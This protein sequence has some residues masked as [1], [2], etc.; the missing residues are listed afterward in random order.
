MYNLI[1]CTVYIR[2]NDIL[3]DVT[4]IATELD[5]VRIKKKGKKRVGKYVITVMISVSLAHI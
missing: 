4:V 5:T 3:K 1:L 2:S